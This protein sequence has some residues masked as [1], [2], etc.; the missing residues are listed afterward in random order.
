[1]DCDMSTGATELTVREVSAV[2]TSGDV[3][4]VDQLE[5]DTRSGLRSLA[6]GDRRRVSG[7]DAGEVIVSTSYLRVVSVVSP[8]TAGSESEPASS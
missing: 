8:T 6:L 4:H 7:L 3:R 5:A 1:M 2:E